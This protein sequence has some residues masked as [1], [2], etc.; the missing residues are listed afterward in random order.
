[1]FRILHGLG[2]KP[3]E[4]PDDDYQQDAINQPAYAPEEIHA[5]IILLMDP[6][7]MI[8]IQKIEYPEQ[9]AQDRK[10]DEPGLQLSVRQP[11]DLKTE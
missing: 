9:G 2:V 7:D 8:P 1:L 11:G 3:N 10:T 5:G 6:D 4:V